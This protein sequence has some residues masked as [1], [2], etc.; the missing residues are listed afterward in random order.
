MTDKTEFSLD[1]PINPASAF[2]PLPQWVAFDLCH[3]YPVTDG[4][5]LLHNT[6]NGKRAMV[7]PE[8]H[9]SLLHCEQ[10]NTISQHTA[11]II[12]LNPGMGDQQ[13]DIRKVLKSML[14]SGIMLSAKSECDRLKV[15]IG[16]KKEESED[17]APV[18]AII[19]WERP[20]AL[21]RLLESIAANC[22]TEKLHHLYIIDDS[23]KTENIIQNQAVVERF[24]SKID[25]P[26]RYFGQDEQQFLLKGLVQQLPEHENAIHFLADQSRWKDLWTSGM[27]R[28]LA[29]LLSCGR[30]LVM[31]DDDAICDLYNPPQQNHNI[32][33]SDS[34]REAEFFGSEQEWDYLRQ[35][36]NPDPIN[37]HMQCLGLSFSEAV[38]VLGENHL[39]PAG[40][41]DATALQ[42][43]ELQPDSTILVTEC[44]SL[45]CPGTA[46]NT[47]LPN[48]APASLKRMLGSVDK[49]SQALSTRKVW[50]GRNHPHFSPYSNMSQITGF[51]N[52]QMLPP[53]L[54]ILR[55]EDQLFGNM[56][57]YVFP[58][59]VV[60]DYPWAVPHLPVP[61]REWRDRDLSFTPEDSF[62]TFFVS[63]I[64]EGRSSCQ[65]TSVSDRLSSLSTWFDNLATS[66]DDSLSSMYRDSRL[67]GDSGRL[68]R[69]TQ[70]LDTSKSAPVN[71]Q[72]YLRN[73][74]S[75]LN[76]DLDLA[77]RNDFVVRGIPATM[78]TDELIIFWKNVWADFA[79]ALKAWPEIRD[80][81]TQV[82]NSMEQ[83]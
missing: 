58:N 59:S 30:R 57:N 83:A 22:D 13:D 74:I 65:S 1:M 4:N 64:V 61:N 55:G 42:L 24:V 78:E 40:F 81:A 72:N 41:A 34:P 47:W 73:G 68:S 37:R 63:K 6:Q 21:E 80:A 53:Y 27:A 16:D 7:R 70:L 66:S 29:L 12:E 52:R 23:R 9:A 11:N 69:L 56:L 67:R 18:V 26:L 75:Q 8:V 5:L 50:S 60:L 79:S 77:S 82:V 33:F 51:D 71:W 44:G 25:T 49:T 17:S 28:N 3:A 10:F 2:K 14:D 20:Q 43:S 62:P 19:T 46:N 45:G 76:T 15:K 31:L 36:L 48:M 32:T 35:P 38:N 54:P 39:K